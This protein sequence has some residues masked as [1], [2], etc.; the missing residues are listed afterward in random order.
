MIPTGTTHAMNII[1]STTQAENLLLL[2]L[3]MTAAILR[4]SCFFN[5]FKERHRTGNKL[6]K[7]MVIANCYR[8]QAYNSK[9]APEATRRKW[10]CYQ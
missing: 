7:C 5:G 4:L 8:K 10:A 6:E 9:D 3:H 1:P 2:S